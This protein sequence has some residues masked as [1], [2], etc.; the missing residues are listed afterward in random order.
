MLPVIDLSGRVLLVTGGSKGLGLAMARGFAQAGADVVIAS[1]KLD[2]CK[3]AASEIAE[4]TGQRCLPVACHVGDWS[5]CA[6][7]VDSTLSEFG[8]VDILINNAGIAPVA[9]SLHGV[10]EELFD[11]TIGVNLKGP[12]RLAAL[13]AEHMPPGGSIINISSVASVRPTP[14]TAVYGAAKAGLNNLTKA[15]ALE[16]APKGIR[17]N[18]IICGT[19]ATDSL[20]NSAADESSLDAMGNLCSL[21]RVAQPSEIVGTALYLATSAS[22]YTNGQLISVDGGVLP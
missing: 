15:M 22:S 7:L 4:A 14:F 5:Q 10:T 8:R 2:A 17:T 9:P 18:G 19:F 20:R 11:K 16:F 3:A 1:R 12:L 21:N 6:E 13:A